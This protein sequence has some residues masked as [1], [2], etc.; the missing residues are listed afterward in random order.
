[1]IVGTTWY[2]KSTMVAILAPGIEQSFATPLHIGS[3]AYWGDQPAGFKFEINKM[4]IA[5]LGD[6]MWE[7]LNPDGTITPP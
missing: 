7:R 6:D 1:L 5:G 3:D 4:I 2:Q